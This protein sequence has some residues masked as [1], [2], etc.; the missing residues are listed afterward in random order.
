M[1]ARSESPAANP[2]AVEALRGGVVESRH[3][4]AAAVADARGRVVLA[5]GDVVR[6]G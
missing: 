2:V 1:D 3:R 6:P 5:G 4:A